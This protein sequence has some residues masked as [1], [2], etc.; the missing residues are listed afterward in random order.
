[1]LNELF[2]VDQ[3]CLTDQSS[4]S[5]LQCVFWILCDTFCHIDTKCADFQ[6]TNEEKSNLLH[7]LVV[8][9]SRSTRRLKMSEKTLWKE[10][11]QYVGKLNRTIFTGGLEESEPSES[12]A[13][14]K[15]CNVYICSK[16]HWLTC[17]KATD[18][19][20]ICCRLSRKLG[21][22][23]KERAGRERRRTQRRAGGATRRCVGR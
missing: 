18:R 21:A 19:R 12:R 2:L 4:S 23:R 14:L 11:F 13:F 3:K 10:L 15:R 1:M 8:A 6:E 16:I 9:V 7:N 20:T 5:F 17:T 22:P